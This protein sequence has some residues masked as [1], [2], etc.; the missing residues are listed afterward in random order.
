VRVCIEILGF[1]GAIAK[2][3]AGINPVTAFPDLVP[4]TFAN[5]RPSKGAAL[6][7][8][9]P[10]SAAG[11]VRSSS[12]NCII[13]WRDPVGAR[14]WDYGMADH[15]LGAFPVV[16]GDSGAPVLNAAGEVVGII[17]GAPKL[18][19]NDPSDATVISPIE[20]IL[21][22][23]QWQHR[24]LVAYAERNARSP[25]A[26][27]SSDAIFRQKVPNIVAHL[28]RDFDLND[29]QAA[30]IM[31]NIGYECGGF[32]YLHQLDQ[33]EGKGGYGWAQWTASRREK[34]LAWC[35]DKN[36][37]WRSDEAN[38]GYLKLELTTSPY[39]AAIAALEKATTVDEAVQ[40]F[41][42]NYEKSGVTNYPS[43]Q[44]WAQIALDVL[45]QSV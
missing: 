32:H 27:V 18:S 11:P 16:E 36:L 24:T 8:L 1:G 28:K 15:I 34:F 6:T 33:P 12:E 37:D 45:R 5:T 22:H 7:S 19:A 17:F 21:A 38:Y 13:A 14:V 10:S 4:L 40:A 9:A 42:R 3:S 30:G 41:E 23:A 29:I 26:E 2:L 31:G 43:R 35:T 39:N 25:R 44:R 20:N